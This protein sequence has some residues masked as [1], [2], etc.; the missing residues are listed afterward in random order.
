MPARDPAAD[1][2]DAVQP[3]AQTLR[4][5]CDRRDLPPAQRPQHVR[6]HLRHA[7]PAITA[8]SSASTS[9]RTRRRSTSAATPTSSAARWWSTTTSLRDR[10]AHFQNTVGGTPGPLDCFLVLRGTKTLHVR[11]ERHCD[12]RRAAS[13]GSSPSPRGCRARSTT[14]GCPRTRSTSWQNARCGA[15]GGMVSFEL[16]ASVEEAKRV[17]AS[18]RSVRAGREPGRRREPGR[19][20]SEHD[21]WLDPA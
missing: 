10:L 4:H 13:P 1:G 21:P 7:L 12:K 16:D 5:R 2:G 9:S 15:R 20:P 17:A 3:A 14:R 18:F 19:P 8:R 11:M 6:Q